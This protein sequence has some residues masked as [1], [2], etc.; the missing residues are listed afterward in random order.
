[1]N[2]CLPAIRNEKEFIFEAHLDIVQVDGMHWYLISLSKPTPESQ[3][4]PGVPRR[5]IFHKG[6]GHEH[7]VE[8][9]IGVPNSLQIV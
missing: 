5:Q 4:N 1:M 6:M 7:Y 8:T 3:S 2:E 9:R